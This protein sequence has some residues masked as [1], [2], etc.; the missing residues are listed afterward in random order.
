MKIKQTACLCATILMMLACGGAPEQQIPTSADEAL[1]LTDLTG[2]YLGQSP[3]GLEPMLF[4]EGLLSTG[5]HDDGAPRFSPDGREVYFRK[6]GVPHD[7]IGFM[8]LDGTRW[9][10]PALFRE[11]GQ[12]IVSVPIFE[13]DGTGAYFLSRRP[14]ESEGE[15]DDYNVWF[16]DKGPDGWGPLTAVG[17]PLN[18]PENEYPY[19][20]ASS[21]TLYLQAKY[22]DTFGEY[23]I[24]YSR[25][26]DGVHEQAR[27]LGSP[28]NTEFSEGA[29]F[30]APD[31]SFLVYSAFGG[32]D[33]LGSIDLY[34][35]FRMEDGTWTPGVNLGPDVNSADADKFPSLSPDGKYLFFVSH[36]GADRSYV[37]SEMTYDELMERNL[38][39]RNGEGDVYWVSAEVIHRL[40]P[41]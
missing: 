19:S 30:V 22:E 7:V 5:L 24:Y 36:R 33:S 17:P 39:P 18:T 6:W 3:P 4:G 27:N 21:G 16:A 40:R 23:D 11:F 2:E 14:L 1:H 31:E 34:V 37:F 32:P 38:G 10:A 20:I 13:T 29:P 25:L 9:T 15:P 28:V 41:E 35:T 12:Y 8:Q 26:I